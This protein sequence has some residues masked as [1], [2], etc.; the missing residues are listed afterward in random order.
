MSSEKTGASVAIIGMYIRDTSDLSKAFRDALETSNLRLES[1]VRH[2]EIVL[3]FDCDR[4]ISKKM[5]SLE[6]NVKKILIVSEPRVVWPF[7]NSPATLDLFDAVA[8]MGR[9]PM[10]GKVVFPI[11]QYLNLSAELFWNENRNTAT[12]PMVNSNKFSAVS[13]ELYSLRRLAAAQIPGVELFGIDWNWKLPGQIKRIVYPFG[14]ALL[15]RENLSRS[16]LN[17]AFTARAES[18]V[19]I[20]DKFRDE[21][22]VAIENKNIFLSKFARSLVVEN[23]QEYM[24]EKLFDALL[25]GTYPIYVGPRLEDYGLPGW[26]CSSAEPDPNSIQRVIHATRDIDLKVWRERVFGWITSSE[27]QRTWSA[28]NVYNSLLAWAGSLH[29]A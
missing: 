19:S 10:D 25:A 15:A 17:S 28:V 2:A 26:L 1:D 7:G 18:D 14:Q 23:S 6:G 16:W 21:S 22:V 11:P 12:L 5:Q 8:W 3:A 4:N 13:G 20:G 9:P 27:V 29:D 24:S